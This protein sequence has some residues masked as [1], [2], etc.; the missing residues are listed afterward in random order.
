MLDLE[1]VPC[2]ISP[3][4]IPIQYQSKLDNILK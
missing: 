3:D 2:P 1:N 4:T